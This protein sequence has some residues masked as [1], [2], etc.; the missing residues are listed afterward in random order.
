MFSMPSCGIA[1]QKFKKIYFLFHDAFLITLYDSKHLS[2]TFILAGCFCRFMMASDGIKQR[3]IVHQVLFLFL[4]KCYSIF[5]VR[6]STLYEL[7]G[8]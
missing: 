6:M 7:L 1:I 4:F 2:Y 5:I 8:H 3:N